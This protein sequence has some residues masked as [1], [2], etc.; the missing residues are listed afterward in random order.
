MSLDVSRDVRAHFLCTLSTNE[1][2]LLAS[3]SLHLIT[4]AQATKINFSKK[5]DSNGDLKARSVSYVKNGQAFNISVTTEV[6]LASGV[7]SSA[8]LELSGIGNSILLSSANITTLIDNP[9]VGENHQGKRLESLHFK[10]SM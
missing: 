9:N 4:G 10:K 1:T 2:F 5:K 3:H 7:H 8:L 6:I